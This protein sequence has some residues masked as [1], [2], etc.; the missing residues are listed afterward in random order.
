VSIAASRAFPRSFRVRLALLVVAVA[1]LSGTAGGQSLTLAEFDGT[2]RDGS[3]QVIRDAEV[4][5]LDRASGATRWTFTS[6]EGVF[7]F[8]ALPSGRYDVTIEAL[9]YGPVVHLDVRVAAGHPTRL[10][11]TLQRIAPPVTTIDTIPRRGDG[12]SAGNWLVERG[13]GD[14]VGERRVGTD[15]AAF[16][17]IADER[18]IEGLP[19]R[20]AESLLDGARA[21]GFGAPG[22][23]GTDA[24]G[25]ALPVRALSVARVG[26]LGYDVEVG[27]TGV[28]LRATTHRG[29]STPSTRMLVEGGT[30]DLGGAFI[31]GGPLQGD[32]AQAVFGGDYQSGERDF[33]LAGAGDPARTSARSSLFGRL[34]WQPSDRLAVS[35][36]ASGSQLTSTGLG[37]RTGLAAAYGTG[38]EALGTQAS[39]NVYARLTRRI[40]HEW[41]ISADVGSVEGREGSVPR[42][43]IASSGSQAGA[44]LG[45]SFQENRTTPR[46]SGMLHFDFGEHRLKLGFATATHRIDSR[47]ARSSDGNFAVDVPLAATSA[48]WTRVEPLTFAGEFR[49]NE[50]ALFVQDAWRVADGLSVILGA[51][52]DNTRLPVGDI[53]PNAEWLGL[54][55]LDNAAVRA[56][57]SSVAPRVGLR[58][59]LG[60]QR[61][62]V[63]EG[64]AGTYTDLPDRRD[65]AEALTFDQ[66]ADV[67]YGFG[68]TSY[69][70][71]PS[72]G[73]APVVGRT[74]TMLAP[75]FTAPRTQRLSLGVTR[76]DGAWSAS[77]NAV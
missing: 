66:A 72:L 58:W 13:F 68:V 14:L 15:L 44:L 16:S 39:L 36:R 20:Y 42:S 40:A 54:S 61:E 48:A 56:K 5:V 75:S 43:D 17:T 64:G 2:V 47:F 53:E 21:G 35:A 11:A 29:G 46:V 71:V 65:I 27:G 24:A 33:P 1:G 18:S 19:W 34:D 31:A 59:E 6:R 45:E 62:W 4:R 77:L 10:D 57:R 49:M 69:P 51:R 25:L 23:T 52:I 12:L 28:G 50:T 76:R 63:I 74:I 8:A 32:T 70:D 9:G 60:P 73:E 30:A 37:E 55:A 22:G 38:Y 41:R 3:R 7:R 67:R 26:G